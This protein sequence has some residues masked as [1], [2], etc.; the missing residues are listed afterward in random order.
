[1]GEEG[2]GEEGFEEG[3]V[4]EG[5]LGGKRVEEGGRRNVVVLERV[6][7]SDELCSNEEVGGVAARDGERVEAAEGFYGSD[8]VGEEDEFACIVHLQRA[9]QHSSLLTFSFTS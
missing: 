7:E 2:T 6:V 9:Y 4:D 3:V 1:M 8:V 5:V